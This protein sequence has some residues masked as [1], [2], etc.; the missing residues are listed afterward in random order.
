VESTTDAIRQVQK[1]HKNK[2]YEGYLPGEGSVSAGYLKKP[3][4]G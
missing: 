4:G 1:T 2:R 3:R